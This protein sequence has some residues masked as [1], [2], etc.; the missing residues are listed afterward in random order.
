MKAFK[1]VEREGVG[2]SVGRCVPKVSDFATT[3]GGIEAP[4]RLN[5][6]RFCSGI[7]TRLLV[8][9]VPPG[10]TPEFALKKANTS[11][12]ATIQKLLYVF[13]SFTSF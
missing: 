13:G 9:K 4:I 10:Q 3:Q 12:L 2:D 6:A 7:D 1:L 5:G 11:V 8:R